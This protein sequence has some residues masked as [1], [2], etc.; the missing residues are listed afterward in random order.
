MSNLKITVVTPSYNQG[1]FLE[2]TI[3]SVVNQDYP[4]L[5]YIIIDGG[6]ND[7]STDIIRR[8]ERQ[9][10]Y[11][12]SEKDK[13]Q[14][15][16]VNKGIMR[17]SGDIVGWLN[18][19]DIY[20]PNTLRRVAQYFESYRDAEVIYGNHVVTDQSN[21]PLW[22]KKEIP[23]SIRRLEHHSYMSQPATFIRRSAIEKVGLLD[24]NLYFLL[25]WEYFIRLGK[26]CKFRHVPEVFATYRLHRIAKTAVQSGQERFA[27]EKEKVMKLHKYNPTRF[28]MVNFGYHALLYI[29]SF[30]ARVF[31]VLRSNPVNYIRYVRYKRAGYR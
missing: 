31:V 1:K 17:S 18:S 21:N 16:A 14:A 3:R 2:D 20:L 11:W 4:S 30:I 13:G 15:D 12:V 7:H 25:D 23:F 5:E 29:V 24:E 9:L 28:E 27:E 26:V 22:V 10:A 8:Y 19:D 6:S